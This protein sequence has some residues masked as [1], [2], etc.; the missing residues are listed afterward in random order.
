[1]T[2]TLLTNNSNNTWT[3]VG[4][5]PVM[6]YNKR[7]YEHINQNGLKVYGAEGH[8]NWGRFAKDLFDGDTT[9]PS[10]HWQ[11]DDDQSSY[12]IMT[13]DQVNGR[14]G[15]FI[16]FGEYVTIDRIRVCNKIDP[17]ASFQNPKSGAWYFAANRVVIQ[18]TSL[19]TLAQ[20]TDTTGSTHFTTVEAF[21]L[22]TD[23][24]MYQQF[25]EFTLSQPLTTK[26]LRLYVEAPHVYGGLS[27]IEVY[28]SPLQ[29][30]PP[31][32][33]S[34]VDILSE[35]DLVDGENP[36]PENFILTFDLSST[37][38]AA[39]DMVAPSTPATQTQTI[40]YLAYNYN[41]SYYT[42]QLSSHD[43]SNAT[44]PSS[45]SAVSLP[46]LD[47]DMYA[48]NIDT[49]LMTWNLR[50]ND[51]H[52]ILSGYIN[53]CT[54]LDGYPLKNNAMIEFPVSQAG[55][56]GVRLVSTTGNGI[57]S[58]HPKSINFD[59]DAY[60]T[61]FVT[62]TT[63]SQYVSDNFSTLS[64]NLQAF[65]DDDTQ[66][67]GYIP[68][69]TFFT[70]FS[71]MDTTFLITASNSQ[72]TFEEF[73]LLQR[74]SNY[75]SSHIDKPSLSTYLSDNWT[76]LSVIVDTFIDLDVSSL[77]SLDMSSF[78][79]SF[80]P[81]VD[82]N[83]LSFIDTSDTQI[84]F[85]YFMYLHVFYAYISTQI[86]DSN[87]THYLY[88]NMTTKNLSNILQTFFD[89]D[90][91]TNMTP[92][93]FIPIAAFN[94]TFSDMIDQQILRFLDTDNDAQV[95]VTELL[96]L[97]VNSEQL[98][99]LTSF[100]PIVYF[101]GKNFK[102]SCSS[103]T[104]TYYLKQISDVGELYTTNN[105]DEASSFKVDVSSVDSNFVKIYLK[106][107][108]SLELRH[109]HSQLEVHAFDSSWGYDFVWGFGP[110]DIGLADQSSISHYY[111]SESYNS[112]TQIMVTRAKLYAPIKA[113]TTNLSYKFNEAY[114]VNHHTSVSTTE[115]QIVLS[116]ISEFD[117]SPTQ[118]I[119]NAAQVEA[120]ITF[121]NGAISFADLVGDALADFRAR[122]AES[123]AKNAGVSVEFVELTSITEGS[124]VVD[125]TVTF[126]SEHAASQATSFSN[127]VST[128]SSS[129]FSNP[130]MNAYGSVSS[131]NIVL[132]DNVT[133]TPFEDTTYT[134]ICFPSGTPV[135]T[136]Q[137]II[138]IQKI[139]TN[140]HTINT[141]PIIAVTH[142]IPRDEHLVFLSQGSLDTVN[143]ISD[144][145][146]SLNHKILY[147]GNMIKAKDIVNLGI[148]G[149]YFIPYN[150]KTILYNILLE[151][152]QTMSVNGIIAETLN[153]TDLIS[154]IYKNIPT[155]SHRVSFIKQLNN[156]L[157]TKDIIKY[158][159]IEQTIDQ[160]NLY[161]SSTMKKMIM[162]KLNIM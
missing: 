5:T 51:T 157:E 129:I 156:A 25:E 76:S 72:I 83:L 56:T 85:S 12:S 135:D 147:N 146:I 131:S 92:T 77:G 126:T 91:D 93:G 3:F 94:T 79:Y 119:E 69:N 23:P 128:N 101:A 71:D 136:D 104:T 34:F 99:A 45:L 137:G 18:S 70:T 127:T 122:V 58:F 35:M 89:V 44:T 110:Y 140:T 39:T 57:P 100:D 152:H 74:L 102:I 82:P 97:F 144:T 37:Y 52:N 84:D 66:N 67:C 16:D 161:Q 48:L 26:I 38:I 19:E 32:L 46:Y 117:P 6:F 13:M 80:T 27:E 42:T 138:Q 105:I 8:P 114:G 53:N 63:L 109:V 22:T 1:M 11:Q 125:F 111:N 15:V 158:K 68:L 49:D 145:Q 75:I 153:P 121:D 21:N 33:R 155:H 108:P 123:I 62:N 148:P 81:L 95:T 90:T 149:I 120:T 24:S 139:N 132:S 106:D 28:G 78:V 65:F 2:S 88:S 112:E 86:S 107:D 96:Q 133:Y 151:K 59:L 36:I 130:S 20:G 41:Q 7:I 143:P 160:L 73:I 50:Y 4:G 134:N 54:T 116:F 150:R 64:P 14:G 98:P 115:P 142:S 154:K 103:S 29:I 124:I 43:L 162:Q 61:M 31:N 10:T 55:A 113:D 47:A 141:N 17:N 9:F 40:Q 118:R 87:L 30:E 60:V 159:W